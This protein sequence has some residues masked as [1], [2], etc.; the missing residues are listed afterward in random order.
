MPAATYQVT[1]TN[2]SGPGSLY[3]AILNANAN[4]GADTITFAANV[5]GTIVLT[6]SLPG[7]RRHVDDQWPRRERPGVSGA[8]TYGVFS[9]T[10]ALR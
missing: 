4:A 5:N 10:P 1:N 3:Q 7:H 2:A 8:N 6:G 9:S